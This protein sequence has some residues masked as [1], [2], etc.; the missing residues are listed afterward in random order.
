MSAHNMFFKALRYLVLT[1]Q[2]TS[3]RDHDGDDTCE[4]G[5]RVL[6]YIEHHQT[7]GLRP[8]TGLFQPWPPLHWL[9]PS[10]VQLR[11]RFGVCITKQELQRAAQAARA[12]A[13]AW[14]DGLRFESRIAFYRYFLTGLPGADAEI[15]QRIINGESPSAVWHELTSGAEV[16][17]GASSQTEPPCDRQDAPEGAG[18]LSLA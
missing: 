13:F 7:L 5:Y 10:L 1:E 3:R 18:A 12:I 17:R 4:G 14:D 11:A 6:G 16:W 2:L 15:V 8:L 9:A